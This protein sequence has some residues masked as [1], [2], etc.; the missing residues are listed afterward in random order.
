M[1]AAAKLEE[2]TKS[3]QAY[4]QKEL[5]KLINGKIVAIGAVVDEEFGDDFG[6]PEVWPVLHVLLPDGT[7]LEVSVSQDEEGNGPGHLF[8]GAI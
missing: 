7:K 6:W 4:V 1:S 8:I 2:R 5:E 3:Q